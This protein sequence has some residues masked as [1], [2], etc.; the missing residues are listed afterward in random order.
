MMNPTNTQI[1][2]SKVET[3]LWQLGHIPLG[4]DHTGKRIRIGKA[5]TIKWIN[6]EQN[7]Y[8]LLNSLTP[9]VQKL[10]S[11]YPTTR[12]KWRKSTAT[13]REKTKPE[14]KMQSRS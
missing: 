5:E 14:G 10:V 4:I 13:F 6:C 7:E 8:M 11:A 12:Q 3:E 2:I 9:E 1:G